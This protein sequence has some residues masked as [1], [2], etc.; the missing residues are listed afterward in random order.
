M[1]NLRNIW[2]YYLSHFIFVNIYYTEIHKWNIKCV[3][4]LS[5]YTGIYRISV[6]STRCY[7]SLAEL[8]NKNCSCFER[9]GYS[10]LSLLTCCLDNKKYHY[11]QIINVPSKTLCK[12]LKDRILKRY[13]YTSQYIQC[14][15]IL[16][17][18][19]KHNEVS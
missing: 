6:R 3:I 13:F 5:L 8:L 19:E 4:S 7:F 9:F 14:N 10:A 15:F 16:V 11:F 1:I 12:V 17:S 2:D 18:H